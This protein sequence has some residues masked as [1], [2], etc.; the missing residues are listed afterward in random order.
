[1]LINGAVYIAIF[2]R[3]ANFDCDQISIDCALNSDADQIC[4]ICALSFTSARD[5]KGMLD[6][7]F[8]L[9]LYCALPGAIKFE[10]RSMVRYLPFCSR[11]LGPLA[12]ATGGAAW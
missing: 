11:W 2:T 9:N 10:G 5:S 3:V 6:I 4:I 1:M 8:V 7:N 12:R